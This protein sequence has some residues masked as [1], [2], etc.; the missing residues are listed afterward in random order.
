MSTAAVGPV[1]DAKAVLCAGLYPNVLVAPKEMGDKDVG[2]LSFS[3][4]K[5]NVNI[6]PCSVVFKDTTLWSRYCVYHEIVKTTK[7]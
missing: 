5:G 2:E 1:D 7:V 4:T 6:H 3:S